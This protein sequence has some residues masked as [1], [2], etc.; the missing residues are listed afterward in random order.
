LHRLSFGLEFE[1]FVAGQESESQ[2]RVRA[3]DRLGQH[4]RTVDLNLC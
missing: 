4:Q 2:G 1:G 3:S